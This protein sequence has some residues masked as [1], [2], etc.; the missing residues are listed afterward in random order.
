MATR[1]GV[2]SSGLFDRNWYLDQYSDVRSAGIDPVLHYLDYGAREGRNPSAQFDTALYLS[3]YPDV[4]DFRHQSPPPLHTTRREGRAVSGGQLRRDLR[5]MSSA[6]GRVDHDVSGDQLEACFDRVRREW[7]ILGRKEPYW[8]VSSQ[9]RHKI[10][11]LARKRR[12]NFLLPGTTPFFNWKVVLHGPGE[13][14][15][16]AFVSNLAAGPAA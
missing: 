15:P 12:K 13:S 1:K 11:R 6:E 3:R 7:A 16:R 8:S 10:A 2:A 9:D 5:A 14:F 4:A